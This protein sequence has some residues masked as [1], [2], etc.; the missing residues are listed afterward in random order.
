YLGA[1]LGL[2]VVKQLV[3][4]MQGSIQVSSAVGVGTTFEFCLQLPCIS[5]NET[6]N[7]THTPLHHAKLTKPA[8]ADYQ[9]SFVEND[10][11]F[12]KLSSTEP[13][14]K[15]LIADDSKINRMVLAGYL[16]ELNCQVIEA[17]DGREAWKMFQEDEIDYVLLD[18][19][20][21]FMDGLQVSENIQELYESGKAPSLKGVFAI[22]AGGDSSGFIDT[23]EG[24]QGLGFDKWLVKPVS[25]SQIISLLDKNYRQ[26]EQDEKTP[27][28]IT[29]PSSDQEPYAEPVSEANH[30][31][32][33]LELHTVHDIPEQFHHLFDSFIKETQL[34]FENLSRYN[35]QNEAE[36]IKKLA[37][38]LKGNCMLFQLPGLVTQFKALETIQEKALSGEIDKQ[39]RLKK[40]EKTLQKIVLIMKSLEKSSMIGHNNG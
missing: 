15:V 3:E 9:S 13:H 39:Q 26:T 27:Q 38:Y 32:S 14:Y 19:Q 24:H 1:G 10:D 12:T 25:K 8:I 36:E 21:P 11:E 35:L 30:L 37:H 28:K 5:E 18:I 2:F 31:S 17:K 7:M 29:N 33:E 23:D 40:T 34:G 22:T 16:A 4:L 20:M 6:K